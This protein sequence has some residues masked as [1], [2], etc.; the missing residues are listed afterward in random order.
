MATTSIINKPA[1][2]VVLKGDLVVVS[3]N[4]V[5]DC[6][7]IFVQEKEYGDGHVH[8]EYFPIHS[9]KIQMNEYRGVMKHPLKIKDKVSLIRFDDIVKIEQ[10][11][12]STEWANTLLIISDMD[13][14]HLY[15]AIGVRLGLIKGEKALV[16]PVK[17]IAKINSLIGENQWVSVENCRVHVGS[18]EISN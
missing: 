3:L 15:F 17:M 13:K 12:G 11:N 16:T 9:F 14:N 4:E 6:V 8:V 5:E 2:T 1:N 7:A 18:I 10:K